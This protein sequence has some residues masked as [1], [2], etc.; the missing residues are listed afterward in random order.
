MKHVLLVTIL[1]LTPFYTFADQSKFELQT[2]VISDLKNY[3]I[4]EKHP[5]ADHIEELAA[6][7]QAAIKQYPIEWKISDRIVIFA[8]ALKL[9]ANYAPMKIDAKITSQILSSF[10]AAQGNEGLDE[11]TVKGILG[12][13]DQVDGIAISKNPKG[14]IIFE[15]LTKGKDLIVDASLF[16]KNADAGK[17]IIRQGM[18]L[19]LRSLINKDNQKDL[20]LIAFQNGN[21]AG[22]INRQFTRSFAADYLKKFE[23]KTSFV[24]MILSLNKFSITANT[25]NGINI[26][27]TNP[28]I[29]TLPSL[30]IGSR[31]IVSGQISLKGVPVFIPMS[32]DH[33]KVKADSKEE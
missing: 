5:L 26:G 27:V 25:K 18:K 19:S 10:K 1:A 23:G 4:Q 13:L 9:M 14:D 12:I 20:T 24:P 22:L 8:E 3:L 16:G 11:G 15:F 2:T 6:S 31:V 30:S 28:E 29:V 33:E 21:P 17:V 7:W 32:L